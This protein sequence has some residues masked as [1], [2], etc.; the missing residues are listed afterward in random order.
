MENLVS[1]PSKTFLLGEYAVL[2]GA[3]ALVLCHAPFFR[4]SWIKEASSF[5][6]DS[7]AGKWLSLQT[8]AQGVN[9]E[10]PYGGSGG[11]GGSTAELAASF[12]LY[13]E[14]K[15][16]E[17]EL[18]SFYYD[19][20][21]SQRAPSG[22]DLFAQLGRKEGLFSFTKN[23]LKKE[24]LD[25]PFKDVQILIYKRK[26]KLPTH[27]H[28]Q[29][30]KREQKFEDMAE[31]SHQGLKALRS[32]DWEEFLGASKSFVDLQNRRG[33]LDP[34]SQDLCLRLQKIEGVFFA[35]GCG[36]R[37]ADV[38]AVFVK[39]EKLNYISACVQSDFNEIQPIFVSE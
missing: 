11:F 19:L 22:A 39:R 27:Q 5:H 3:P 28:L 34:G 2:A 10:D 9:F 4:A 23:P 25:W 35:R 33:L 14:K 30:L 21:S 37:G 13:N 8:Q 31:F 1:I 36:A 38:L 24:N 16:S 15:L 17:E 26:V 32:S 6:P 18:M 7:P 12:Y 29:S 20:F